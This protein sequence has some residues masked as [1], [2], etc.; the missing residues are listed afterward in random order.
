MNGYS[1]G[2][3]PGLRGTPSSRFAEGGHNFLPFTMFLAAVLFSSACGYHLG[4]QGD[5]IPKNVKTIAIPEFSNGTMQY[6]VASL[7][8]ADVIREFHSRTHYTITTNRDTADAVL[9]GGVVRL[10]V[11]GGITTDPVT[12]RATSAQI[13]LNVQFTLTDRKTG[14]VIYQR[15]GYEFRDRYEIS[16]TNLATYFDESSPAVKRVS[17]AAAAGIVSS[18]LEAF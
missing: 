14:K 1:W 10:D 12:T 18:I 17:R 9:T 16:T 5:L 7:L 13:V 2:R 8:T 4:G 6:Q 15:S 3:P 11:L